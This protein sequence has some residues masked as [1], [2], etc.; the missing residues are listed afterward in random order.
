MNKKILTLSIIASLIASLFSIETVFALT[1]DYYYEYGDSIPTSYV[2]VYWT[3]VKDGIPELVSG[4]GNYQKQGNVK[5]SGQSKFGGLFN[6]NNATSLV[7]RTGS[8]GGGT[9]S[10]TINQDL[11]LDENEEWGF[12]LSAYNDEQDTFGFKNLKITIDNEEVTLN[13]GVAKGY[14]KPLILYATGVSA[15][16][17][18]LLNGGSFTGHSTSDPGHSEAL[19]VLFMTNPSHIISHINFTYSA[20]EFVTASYWNLDDGRATISNKRIEYEYNLTYELNEGIEQIPNPTTYKKSDPDIYLNDPYREGYD[21]MGWDPEGIIP[22]GSKGDK[23]FEAKWERSIYTVKFVDFNNN[24]LKTENLYYGESATAPDNYEIEG[25]DFMG[26][27]PS[28]FSFI[29]S[30]MTIHGIYH[31]KTYPVLITTNHNRTTVLQKALEHFNTIT[32]LDME[33]NEISSLTITG[34]YKNNIEPDTIYGYTFKSY[35]VTDDH[36]GN[37]FIKPLYNA[38]KYKVSFFDSDERLLDTQYVEYLCDAEPPTPPKIHGY[39][40]AGWDGSYLNI[41]EDVELKALYNEDDSVPRWSVTFAVDS[42]DTDYGYFNI[43]N[44]IKYSYTNPKVIDTTKLDTILPQYTVNRNCKFVGWYINDEKVNPSSYKVT[45]I[46]NVIVKFMSD[47][48]FNNID[49]DTESV[50]ITFDSMGGSY[51][52]PKTIGLNK[53]LSSLESP[54]KD[55]CEFQGWYLSSGGY[56]AFDFSSAITKDM[57]LYAKWKELNIEV[58]EPEPVEKVIKTE[59]VEEPSISVVIP[60]YSGASC[61]IIFVNTNDNISTIDTLVKYG[62]RFYIYNLKE[63]KIREY[64]ARQNCYVYLPKITIKDNQE[65]EWELTWNNDDIAYHLTPKLINL[66]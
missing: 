60:D 44:N 35:E 42:G 66:Q 62:T 36:E 18:N 5:S 8:G 43:D 4:T 9:V 7:N 34:E 47:V 57:T 63:Q 1:E 32:Y 65:I 45:D 61:Q 41:T 55:G 25:Y 24:V 52:K 64:Q 59:V 6:P 15:N 56:Q 48:N 33:G 29:K 14:I 23:H 27:D 30:S 31:V 3:N 51:I 22:S 17:D 38:K 19:S 54:T 12:M 53:K 16:F 13:E 46:T 21:F 2:D 28:D 37:Y 50:T 40:F 20:A 10:G 26:W 11:V 58:Q 49:D 39:T